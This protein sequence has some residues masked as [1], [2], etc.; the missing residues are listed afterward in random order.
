MPAPFPDLQ[1]IV[2]GGKR[3]LARA[4]ALIETHEGTTELAGLLDA[5]LALARAHVAGLTGPPG[6][7]KST[8]T[9]AL[10]RDWRGR[11][12]TIGVIAV[13]PSSRRTGGALL[14]DRARA[15]RP[16]PKIKA[17]CAL[18]GRARPP[19]W[20]VRPDCRRRR[21]DAR[22]VRPGADRKRRHRPV[23]SRYFVRGG[24]RDFL[25]AS[26]PVRAIPCNS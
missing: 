4:L 2:A 5:A 25:L 1:S 7:G 18:H 8:L 12:E 9:N 13:D 16:T 26:S 22:A 3:G 11:G 15:W 23:G 24:Q 17:F 6:V 21:F 19:W 20:P 10:L 14:G